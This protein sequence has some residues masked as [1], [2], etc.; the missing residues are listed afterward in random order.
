MVLL[1]FVGHKLPSYHI[2]YV[3]MHHISD[4]GPHHLVLFSDSL[5]YMAG[6][7]V[8]DA[9]DLLYLTTSESLEYFSLPPAHCW[10]WTWWAWPL[11][12]L[13]SPSWCGRQ[14]VPWAVCLLICVR[15]E[16]VMLKLLTHLKEKWECQKKIG[17]PFMDAK[18]K[19]SNT[20]CTH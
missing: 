19:L 17:L 20:W 12:S 18:G 2:S 6:I 14:Q 9:L 8:D 16:V 3:F 4:T 1:G 5:H 10:P 15:F 7:I 13:L 11:W